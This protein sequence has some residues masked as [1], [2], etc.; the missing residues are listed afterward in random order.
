MLHINILKALEDNPDFIF[1]REENENLLHETQFREF[2]RLNFQNQASLFFLQSPNASTQKLS[3]IVIIMAFNMVSQ[4]TL[5]LMRYHLSV[6]PYNDEPDN[7][8]LIFREL[9]QSSSLNTTI[10]PEIIEWDN[11]IPGSSGIIISPALLCRHFYKHPTYQYDAHK[12]VK[13][14]YEQMNFKESLIHY[15]SQIP[16]LVHADTENAVEFVANQFQAVL[17]DCAPL[18]KLDTEIFYNYLNSQVS[19][20]NEKSSGKSLKI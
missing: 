11:K 8:L 3:S 1:N 12:S 20:S 14:I 7:E 19:E 17:L 4:K 5:A 10:K 16:E 9:N 15:I 18:R 2:F 6:I 13:D